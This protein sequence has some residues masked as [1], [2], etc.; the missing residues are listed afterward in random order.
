MTIF[1]ELQSDFCKNLTEF[2]QIFLKNLPYLTDLSPQLMA[3]M[4]QISQRTKWK[5]SKEEQPGTVPADQLQ[6]ISQ[7]QQCNQLATGSGLGNRTELQLQCHVYHLMDIPAAPYLTPAS[8]R[9]RATNSGKEIGAHQC[10]FKNT[11]IRSKLARSGK[12]NFLKY[13]PQSC[14]KPAKCAT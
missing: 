14:E 3:C 6:Q 7:H 9:T 13:L 5:K 4:I 12:C 2:D 10:E 11:L 8:T 1:G